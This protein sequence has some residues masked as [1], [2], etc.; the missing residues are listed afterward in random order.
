MDKCIIFL[1]K[2]ENY[3]GSA[4]KIK[5]QS[6]FYTEI[7]HI[8]DYIIDKKKIKNSII[9][10][11]CNSDLVKEIVNIKEIENCYIFNKKFFE[12]NYSKL[13]IQNILKNNY[14]KVPRIIDKSSMNKINFPTFCK[15]DRHGGIV[16]KTYTSNTISRFFEKFNKDDFYLEESIIAQEELKLYFIRDFIYSK[17][18]INDVLQTICTKVSKCLQLEIFSIDII[19]DFEDNFYVIDVNPSAGFY[20]LDHARKELIKNI[21]NIMNK[22][23][24]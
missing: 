3:L 18:N 5:E 8:E 24:K 23:E 11:L 16:L 4:M 10:F 12:N 21:E 20:M 7:I 15:E 1:S 13:E 19:K 22:G 2:E 14:I 6:N 17:G 9:Y